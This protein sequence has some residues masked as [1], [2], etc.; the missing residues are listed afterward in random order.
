MQ[1]KLE[2]HISTNFPFLQEKKLLIAISGGV[3]SVVLTQL[4][5]DLKFDISLA[6]CNFKLRDQESELDALFVKDLAKSGELLIFQS[7]LTPKN[8]Q[9]STN[10]LHKL[11]QEIFA[12]SG[13][14][15]C[16]IKIS[17]IIF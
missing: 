4:F 5:F 3:D 1:H 12:M 2:Q 8:M 6:H 10:N 7:H 13:F 16:A 11:Q 9:K 17:L 14:K 15:S